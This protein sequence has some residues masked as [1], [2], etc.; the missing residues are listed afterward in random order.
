RALDATLLKAMNAEMVHRGPDDEGVYVD[1]V[2]GVGLGARRLSIIDVEGG[3]Q[4]LSN[5]DGSIWAVLNGEIYNHPA[6]LERLR[7]R[8]HVLSSRSD[9]EV[10]VHLYEDY[11]P[12]LVHALE[13]M[14]AFAI[15]DTRERRLL[16]GRDRFGEKPLFYVR[17]A[18]QIT[19]ASE[20]TALRR[21]ASD[22]AW[23][24]DPRALDTY[25]NFGYVTGVPSVVSG[26]EQS[27][28]GCTLD[29]R[30]GS[31]NV[32]RYWSPPELPYHDETPGFE[33]VAEA[34]E[35]L[36]DSVRSRRIADVPL[37]V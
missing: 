37:G 8:G 13:G 5:E 31:V 2:S 34:A 11:G 29:W 36:E 18:D 21:G 28:P 17:T 10:L 7:M 33:L 19:F 1:D 32:S 14:F 23:D 35:L 20:L 3:H 4:P 30:P 12:D 27:E 6:L 25:F 16:L 26:V 24:I 15:W 9:T 22:T